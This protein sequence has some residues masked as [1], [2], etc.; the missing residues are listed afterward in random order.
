VGGFAKASA[1]RAARLADGYIGTGDMSAIYKMYVEELR[2]AGKD[3]AHGRVAGGFFWL[4]VANDPDKAWAAMAPHVQ[5]Q[6]N[7]Y[8]A[9]TK[10]AGME[11]FPQMP[12]LEALKA[13]GI[14]QVM[15]PD[16]AVKAIIDYAASVP[17]ERFY[18]WTIPPGFPV[19]QMDEHL[20]LMATKVMPHFR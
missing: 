1:R 19:R 10:K 8:A 5:F 13:S 15:T 3:P 9:W 14:F 11:L 12:N 7:V 6:I 4:V 16:A 20:E 17:I 2:A 18:T